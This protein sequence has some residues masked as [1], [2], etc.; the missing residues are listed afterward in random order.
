MISIF[1]HSQ[2]SKYGKVVSGMN[3]SVCVRVRAQNTWQNS[4]HIWYFRFHSCKSVSIEFQHSFKIC[5]IQ[6][7]P[8]QYNDFLENNSN[9]F[10]K[11]SVNYRDH[12]PK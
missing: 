2:P 11:I 5:G 8:K 4:I 1:W 10:D 3:A 6:M 12:V 9:D 7:S